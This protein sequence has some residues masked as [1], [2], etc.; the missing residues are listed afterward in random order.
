M[1]FVSLFHSAI[2]VVVGESTHSLSHTQLHAYT[3]ET[4]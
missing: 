1:L 2:A 3:H 4:Q